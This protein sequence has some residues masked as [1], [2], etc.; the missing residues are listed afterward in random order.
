ME[1]IKAA[2]FYR[3][4]IQNCRSAGQ[5]IGYIG[6][7]HERDNLSFMD[8]VPVPGLTPDDMEQDENG[9]WHIPFSVA[10]AAGASALD[11]LDEEASNCCDKA[12]WQER[13]RQEP[14]VLSRS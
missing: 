7:Q 3:L 4:V 11:C 10:L 1:N 8:K 6:L 2:D 5:L 9:V 13:L 12:A 14:R